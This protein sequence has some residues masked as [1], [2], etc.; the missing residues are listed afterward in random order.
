MDSSSLAISRLFTPV[1]GALSRRPGGCP[2]DYYSGLST[3]RGHLGRFY[4]Y[5]VECAKV[6]GLPGAAVVSSAGS[7]FDIF[8]VATAIDGALECVNDAKTMESP[9][10]DIPR[11]DTSIDGA[12][13]WRVG[14][15]TTRGRLGRVYTRG[16]I[17]SGLLVAK[18]MIC[19]QG[20]GPPGSAALCPSGSN[21]DIS[22]MI[23]TIE[24]ALWSGFG[25][26]AWC[27]NGE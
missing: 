16:H 6:V 20:V 5:E 2:P 14:V 18:V 17:D 1:D 9:S 15:L 10:L 22:R 3:T 27:T 19:A 13:F 24:G 8:W 25:T 7:H 11:A 12:L 23:T 26:V 21:F 4:V